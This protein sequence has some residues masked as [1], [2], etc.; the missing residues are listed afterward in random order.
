MQ[1]LILRCLI[2]SM[3]VLIFFFVWGCGCNFIPYNSD[4]DESFLY[5]PDELYDMYSNEYDDDD[6]DD[7]LTGNDCIDSGGVFIE[8]MCSVSFNCDSTGVDLIECIMDFD[9]SLASIF[10]N[11]DMT[12]WYCQC[13][14]EFN[15]A[16]GNDTGTT[17]A[18]TQFDSCIESY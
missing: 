13:I 12:T 2:V 7:N 3:T 16:N 10:S 4:E 18:C 1:K 5:F 11:I 17:E 14:D 6:E 9:G 15:I 8:M